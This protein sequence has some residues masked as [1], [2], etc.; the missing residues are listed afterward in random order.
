ML[1]SEKISDHVERADKTAPMPEVEQGEALR[2]HD[3][4]AGKSQPAANPTH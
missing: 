3:A 1:L 4:A 2:G